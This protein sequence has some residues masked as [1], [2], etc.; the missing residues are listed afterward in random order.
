MLSYFFDHDLESGGLRN[1]LK[2]GDGL[3]GQELVEYGFVRDEFHEILQIFEVG[4]IVDRS[5]DKKEFC[6]MLR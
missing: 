3:G 5:Q 2:I 4:V 1:V 6:I